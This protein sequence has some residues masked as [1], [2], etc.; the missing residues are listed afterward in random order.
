MF[1]KLAYTFLAVAL[2]ACVIPFAAALTLAPAGPTSV[3]YYQ[4]VNAAGAAEA[5]RAGLSTPTCAHSNDRIPR[6]SV[7]I[8]GPVTTTTAATTTTVRQTTTS[9]AT[10]T[11]TTNPPTTTT[12][13]TSGLWRPSSAHSIAWDWIISTTPTARSG[14]GVVDIDGFGSTAANVTAWHAVGAKVVCYLDAG[15]S[16]NFRPDFG[17]FPAAVQG[18]TNG[19]PGEKW[20]DIRNA[21]LLPIMAA[22]AQMCAAKGFDAIEWDNVDGYDGNNTGFPLTAANQTAYNTWLAGE[23]HT[24]GL[25][26]ALKNDVSQL[27]SLQPVFDFAINEECQA[28]S[29]CGGYSTFTN[30]GKAVFEAEYAA[31]NLNC[32]AAAAGHRDAVRFAL[33]L[34]G[35]VYQ[36]CPAW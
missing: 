14:L 18:N 11:T 6:W 2:M 29:E 15:T 19:W 33:N 30:A 5:S 26:V 21:A 12:V 32:A 16:E 27:S 8:P 20:L 31:G 34:D 3:P 4:C 23:A 25:S 28:F 17:A 24:V 22:R 35:T 13:A 7:D 10:A 9:T 1:R 36:P